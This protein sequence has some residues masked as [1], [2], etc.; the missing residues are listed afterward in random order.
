MDQEH[1]KKCATNAL[2]LL[3]SATHSIKGD[4]FELFYMERALPLLQ[5]IVSNQVVILTQEEH[6]ALLANQKAP[7]KKAK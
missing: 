7:R 5:S 2:E 6:K 4:Q 1:V 3:R